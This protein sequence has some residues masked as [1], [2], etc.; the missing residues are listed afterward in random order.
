MVSNS[1]FKVLL[2]IFLFFWLVRTNFFNKENKKEQRK[3]PWQY[4]CPVISRSSNAVLF[5]SISLSLSVLPMWPCDSCELWPPLPFPR[6]PFETDSAVD[7]SR[8]T[9]RYMER[10]NTYKK[11]SVSIA[12]TR[13]HKHTLSAFSFNFT[14][15]HKKK[16]HFLT[17]KPLLSKL[18]PYSLTAW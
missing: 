10:G 5:F 14:N 7:F 1:A 3:S 2:I 11:K 6:I 17:F 9:T 18:L 16:A 12:A 8:A 4:L 13:S 15:P